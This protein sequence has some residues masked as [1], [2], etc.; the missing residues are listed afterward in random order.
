MDSK[1]GGASSHLRQ[2]KVAWSDKHNER[3]DKNPS[4]E[5]IHP[6]LSKNNTT[7]KAPN[8]PNLVTL[9]RQIR[10]DYFQ[11]HGRHMP[12]R[13][14]SKASPLKESVT[15]MPHGGKETDV[16]HKR[17]VARLEREF[18]IRCIRRYNHRDEYC[19][20]IGSYN[21][22]GHEVWDMYDH[23]NHKMVA[24]SRAD[25]RK[26]QDI[27]AEETGMPRGNPAYETRRKWLTAVEYKV[28]KKEEKLKE[29]EEMLNAV[30][31]D[32]DQSFT[33]KDSLE[34]YNNDLSEQNDKLEQKKA[35]LTN[36][37][38][39]AENVKN[40]MMNSIQTVL[41]TYSNEHLTVLDITIDRETK[42]TISPS[43]R[44][45]TYEHDLIKVGVM[46]NQKKEMIVVDQD[47]YYASHDPIKKK[48]SRIFADMSATVKK[49]LIAQGK[50]RKI[51]G[52]LSAI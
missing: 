27:V 2:C 11:T 20:E 6:E 42:E 15:L 25:L 17:L 9:D 5:N 24:L 41:D 33:L 43:G 10:K 32:V 22:H 38:K 23:K 37:I 30:T 48:I 13:G 16:I 21:W 26:W 49:V 45:V 7:W 47:D 52:R 8:V 44:P 4:N 50:T 3:L 31:V 18:G 35:A 1:K 34:K 14:P 46:M 12:N 51:N 36:I 39:M 19:E 40:A 28:K 29:L